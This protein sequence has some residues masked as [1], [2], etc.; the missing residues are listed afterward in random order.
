[1]DISKFKD[2]LGDDFEALQTYINDLTGQR[3]A[4]R[5]ESIDGRK[6]MK[7]KL[8]KLEADHTA[9]L[10]KLGIDSV[11]DLENLPD[12]KGAADSAKQADAA[13]KR[14]ERERDEALKARDE[15]IGSLRSSKQ[16]AAIAD[17]LSGHEFIA[18]DLVESYVSQRLTWEG[19]ELLFKGEGDK[20]I[21]LADGVAGIA[22]TRPEL[23]KPTGTGGAGVRQ[24]NARGGSGVDLSKLS[25]VERLN[26]A[27]GVTT[28]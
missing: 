26:V 12:A 13:R 22:K 7:D 27:R 2:K 10:E 9:M 17:A 18:R 21:P 8:A 15:A 20:L 19:D 23:L 4:A 1:M 25:P 24:S 16:R 14:A 11:D 5:K 3:D 28:G 6:G